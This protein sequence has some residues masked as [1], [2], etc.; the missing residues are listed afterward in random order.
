MQQGLSD[1]EVAGIAVSGIILV[2]LVAVTAAWIWYGRKRAAA[3]SEIPRRVEQLRQAREAA[4][5][6]ET[7]APG[8]TH[9]PS[10]GAAPTPR[11]GTPPQVPT[12][13]HR[14]P[15]RNW[16]AGN[17]TVASDAT[18]A[19]TGRRSVPPGDAHGTPPSGLAGRCATSTADGGEPP[20]TWTLPRSHTA[21]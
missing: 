20:A 16:S 1:L 9:E 15:V 13:V 7:V 19:I 14:N 17:G 12:P 2:V 6:A 3:W 11:P 4:E 21:R 18:T 8:A 5:T 10:G